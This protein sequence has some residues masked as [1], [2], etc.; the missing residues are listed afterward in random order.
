MEISPN[1]PIK[2]FSL[3]NILD[4]CNQLV[5]KIGTGPSDT[6]KLWG[7]PRNGLIIAG[8]MAHCGELEIRMSQPFS[9]AFI[10]PHT[11]VVDD[12]HDSG[13]TLT[14]YIMRGMP[15]ATLFW[16]KKNGPKPTFFVETIEDD[17]WVV[18]PWEKE[19][20]ITPRRRYYESNN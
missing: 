18:F 7:I 17:T 4:L 5:K 8:L 12:I 2:V 16:R 10:D 6:W 14:P 13:K 3:E 20:I 19:R 11:L 15:T 9:P 1:Q